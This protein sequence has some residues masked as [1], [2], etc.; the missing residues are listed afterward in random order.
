MFNL[1]EDYGRGYVRCSDCETKIKTSE[2]AGRYFAG[3]YC[4]D[5]WDGKWKAIEAKENY[6]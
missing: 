6:E 4:K 5:C 3:V 1:C 2:I